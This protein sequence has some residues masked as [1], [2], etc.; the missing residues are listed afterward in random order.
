M[1]FAVCFLS[2]GLTSNQPRKYVILEMLSSYFFCNIHLILK[3]F[4]GL[5]YISGITY[6]WWCIFKC[7]CHQ[8]NGGTGPWSLWWTNT[9]GGLA[10]EPGESWYPCAHCVDLEQVKAGR[11]VLK[12]YSIFFNA[13][14]LYQKN[15]TKNS[16]VEINNCK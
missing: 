3:S 15:P 2:T 7:V 5:I 14:Y 11:G 10:S 4:A 16:G 6:L 8:S 9:Q 13:T 1:K 12:L